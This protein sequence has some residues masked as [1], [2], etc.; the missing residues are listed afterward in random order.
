LLLFWWRVPDLLTGGGWAL[1][2]LIRDG[3]SGH[4]PVVSVLVVREAGLLRLDA[5]EGGDTSHIQGSLMKLRR[6]AVYLRACHDQQGI[7]A[8]AHTE[9]PEMGTDVRT[10]CVNQP[11]P[12]KQRVAVSN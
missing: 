2:H 4:R 3:S 10:G 1:R 5:A 7:P 8:L 9:G 11:G 6:C 12:R